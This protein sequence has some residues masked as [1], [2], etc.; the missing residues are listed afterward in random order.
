MTPEEDKCFT[1]GVALAIAEIAS[2]NSMKM[3]LSSCGIRSIQDLEDAEVSDFD[4]DRL[5]AVLHS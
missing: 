3:A 2:G 1:R 4:I 5:R